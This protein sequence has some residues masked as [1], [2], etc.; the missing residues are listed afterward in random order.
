MNLLNHKNQEHGNWRNNA[1]AFNLLIYAAKSY[2]NMVENNVDFEHRPD[3]AEIVCIF[4][5]ISRIISKQN[6]HNPDDWL[7]IAGY[8]LLRYNDIAE[9]KAEI[10]VSNEKEQI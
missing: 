10:I 9:N 1:K 7:D 4:Q 8:A 3:F 2:S 5:K 6:N